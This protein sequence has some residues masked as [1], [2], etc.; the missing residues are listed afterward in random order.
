M[1]ENATRWI[2]CPESPEDGRRRRDRRAHHR[3][4]RGATRSERDRDRG[5]RCQIAAEQRVTDG[6]VS[7]D[8]HEVVVED[9]ETRPGSGTI[10]AVDAG[11]MPFEVTVQTADSVL[12]G[13][14]VVVEDTE[15]SG[16][17][18]VG[19]RPTAR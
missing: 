11:A 3:E 14:L 8:L 1:V 7:R 19:R 10:D 12:A 2:D 18:C 17:D 4:T 15:I 13:G 16:F 6:V 9:P 5:R